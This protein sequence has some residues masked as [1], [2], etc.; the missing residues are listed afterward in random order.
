MTKFNWMTKACGVFLL[1]A[2]AA[3]ALPAQTFT[4]LFSFDGTDGYGPAAGLVQGT[5]GLLYGTTIQGANSSCYGGLGCGTVFKVT[6]SGTVTTLYDFDGT[7]GAG[8]DGP[9]PDGALVQGPNGEF[10]GT[11]VNGG[12]NGGSIGYGTVFKITPGGTLTT[13]LSFDYTNGAFPFAGLVQATNGDF[14][15]TTYGGGANSSCSN[16][17]GTVFKIT[18]GGTLTTLLSFDGTDGSGP[19]GALVQA[20]NGDLYGTTSF[21]GIKTSPCDG[22]CGTVFKITLGGALTTIHRFEATDGS[23]PSAGLL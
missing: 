20:T 17:C 22:G 21:G 19:L 14:Y 11:T 4:S 5:N 2:M 1:W 12:A 10:Y 23:K 16:G 18:P 13:L 15:G 7:D 6:P 3:A 9:G 8:P